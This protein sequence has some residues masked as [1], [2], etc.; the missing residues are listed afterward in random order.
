MGDRLFS[1]FLL[2]GQ[3]G[4]MAGDK[5]YSSMRDRGGG[6]RGDCG[7]L[8]SFGCY[9]SGGGGLLPR[10]H[11]NWRLFTDHGPDV[12]DQMQRVVARFLDEED[13]SVRTAGP[14]RRFKTSSGD[15]APKPLMDLRSKRAVVPDKSAANSFSDLQLHVPRFAALR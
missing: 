10:T 12:T 13:L 2:N 7:D 1:L 15:D 8:N 14:K 3:T 11:N 4:K 9:L 6:S 5:P